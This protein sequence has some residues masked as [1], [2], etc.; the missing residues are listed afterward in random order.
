[1]QLRCCMAKYIDD[2]LVLIPKSLPEFEL[3]VKMKLNEKANFSL[4][5]SEI[6]YYWKKLSLFW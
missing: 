6:D 4:N 3:R 5:I 2:I 1:M